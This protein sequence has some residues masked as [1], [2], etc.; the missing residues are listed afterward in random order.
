MCS[1][2]GTH[3]VLVELESVCSYY[4]TAPGPALANRVLVVCSKS[5]ARGWYPSL[6]FSVAAYISKKMMM[7]PSTSN[8]HINAKGRLC[9]DYLSMF[10]QGPASV[11]DSAT[12]NHHSQM[13]PFVPLSSRH[14]IRIYCTSLQANQLLPSSPGFDGLQGPA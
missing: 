6:L 10:G 1:T 14:F 9:A 4:Y 5:W 7:H 13:C 11:S 8:D 12:L 2:A 3:E